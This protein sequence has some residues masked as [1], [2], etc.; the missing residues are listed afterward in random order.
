MR[1]VF[2]RRAQIDIAAIYDWIAT[3]SPGSAQRV[4]DAIRAECERIALFPYASMPTDET[5][6]RRVPLVRYRY[7]IYF[8]VSDEH[9]RVEIARVIHGARIKNLSRL[10]DET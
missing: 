4:E 1:V 7:T 10:P 2:A 5:D 6:V 8:R 3:R 9:D